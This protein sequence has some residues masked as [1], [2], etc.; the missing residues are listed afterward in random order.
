MAFKESDFVLNRPIDS[1]R[2]RMRG[3]LNKGRVRLSTVYMIR[4]NDMYKIGFSDSPHKRLEGLQIGNPYHLELIW[5]DKV[6][7]YLQIEE[8]L[9]QKFASKRERGEW[10]KLDS[11]DIE[12][13]LSLV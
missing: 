10:F 6:P 11:E 4:C 8:G 12:F 13:V 1:E 2:L 7:N 9:H 3:L 5:E